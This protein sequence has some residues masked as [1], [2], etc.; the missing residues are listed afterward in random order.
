MD[1]IDGAINTVEKGG[2]ATAM[3]FLND[4]IEWAKDTFCPGVVN[5]RN[6]SSGVACAI[7][8]V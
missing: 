6:F 2:G 3:A 8:K 7:A 1:V 4:R 5:G